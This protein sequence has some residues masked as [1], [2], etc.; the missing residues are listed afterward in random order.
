MV[1]HDFWRHPPLINRTG[2]VLRGQSVRG[3]LLLESQAMCRETGAVL[4]FPGLGLSA[5][6]EKCP[7]ASGVDRSWGS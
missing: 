3:T 5:T 1:V 6:R 4:T 2:L 7:P